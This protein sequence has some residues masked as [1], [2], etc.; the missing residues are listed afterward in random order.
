MRLSL[1]DLA[2]A[3]VSQTPLLQLQEGFSAGV[4]KALFLTGPV[5]SRWG[6]APVSVQALPCRT[7]GR[8]TL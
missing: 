7:A 3:S 6:P 5:G 4:L 2:R 1:R 8:R